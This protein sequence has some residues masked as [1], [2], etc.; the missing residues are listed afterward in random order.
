MRIPVEFD[1][2]NNK[3]NWTLKK[4]VVY[5]RLGRYLWTAPFLRT[6]SKVLPNDIEPEE[7]KYKNDKISIN[8]A[9]KKVCNKNRLKQK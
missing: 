8:D 2:P 6:S 5:R 3:K 4:H 1:Q 7:T 9:E